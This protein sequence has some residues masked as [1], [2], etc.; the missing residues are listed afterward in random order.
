MNSMKAV[1]PDFLNKKIIFF[2][3]VCNLCN[4]FI[5]F[6]IRR[7][8]DKNIYYASLQSEI[9]VYILKEYN[10]ELTDNFST[11]YFLNNGKLYHRSTAILYVLNNLNF[12]YRIFSKFSLIFPER[13]RNFVYDYISRNRYRFFGKKETCRLPSIE[14]RDQF[15]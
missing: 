7:D 14:E 4:G 6:V 11:I 8:K 5:D 1:K 2:D 12:F 9:G 10:V 13:F 3:G 15:L